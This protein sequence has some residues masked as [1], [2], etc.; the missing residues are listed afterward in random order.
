MA[1]TGPRTAFDALILFERI[2]YD[3]RRVW[4]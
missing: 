3:R 2:R 4:A 1:T